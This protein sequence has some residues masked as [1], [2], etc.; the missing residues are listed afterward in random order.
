MK[1]KKIEVTKKPGMSNMGPDVRQVMPSA[2]HNIDPFVFLDHYGPF[3]KQ[4]GWIG[5]HPHPHA[6]ISTIT[7]IVEGT[8]RHQDSLGNNEV[9][10]SG[11]LAWM[12]A[13]KGII[14]AEGYFGDHKEPETSHGLQ[15]WITLP[16]KDKF[17]DPNFFHYKKDTLPSFKK[18]NVKIK[19]LCGT[20]FNETSPAKTLSSIFLYEL[21]IPKNEQIEVP[22][23]E[24][25]N[26][27]LYIVGGKVLCD[28]FELIPTTISK[29]EQSGDT[30]LLEAKEDS[31]I[32]LLGGKPLNEPIVGYGSYVMNNE[33][34]IKQVMA[35]YQSGKMG[36]L[37]A[38]K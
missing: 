29:F 36:F 26:C 14:H 33:D 22:I 11:D 27:G 10:L 9:G 4:A 3:E 38:N 25:D 1:Y 34:Q 2:I 13:G 37:K 23:K 28:E 16:A 24:G 17:T 30:V 21:K 15:F 31:H 20:L 5:V 35:D 12:R 19:V 7:Y 32:I 6:G 18:E 8:N